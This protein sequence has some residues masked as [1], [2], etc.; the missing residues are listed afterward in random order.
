[1]I[2]KTIIVNEERNVNVTAYIQQVEGEFGFS[3]RPAMIVLPGGGYV[4]C[5]DR[6]ADAVALSYLNAGYQAFILR[7]TVKEFGAWPEPLNDYEETYK[8]IEEHADEW[9]IDTKRIAVVGFSAGGHL[10][11][12]AATVAKHKPAAAILV[13][14]A[15]LKEICDICQP[16]MPYPNECVDRNTCPCFIAAASDDRTVPIKNSLMFELA[17]AE[18]E[19]PFESHIYSYGGHGFSTGKD[20]IITNTVSSRVPNWVE[21]S[22]EWLGENIGQLT[23][24]GVTEPNIAVS[25]NGNYAPILSVACSL[26]H[27]RKQE[28]KVQVLLKPMYDGIKAVATQRGYSEEKLMMVLGENTIRELMETLQIPEEQISKINK[29]LSGILNQIN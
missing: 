26:S 12:C 25:K 22:I 17:L 14:P 15:I 16:N 3:K 2:A 13:Y 23:Y 10:A 24:R 29:E 21:D 4:G 18:N 20:W 1:M 28:E 27:I 9:H 5:S 19:V 11:A 6:E 8:M 7:Y